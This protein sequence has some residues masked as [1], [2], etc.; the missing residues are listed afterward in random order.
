MEKNMPRIRMA[1][2]KKYINSINYK[3]EIY[4]NLNPTIKIWRKNV[5]IRTCSE[6]DEKKELNEDN[7]RFYKNDNCYSWKCRKCINKKERERT[8]NSNQKRN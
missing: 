3:I 7:F 8:K 5:E 4:L 1:I 6:C 2:Y